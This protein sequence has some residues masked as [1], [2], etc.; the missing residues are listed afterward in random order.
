MAA[1]SQG[2]DGK[3][4]AGPWQH[5]Q[6]DNMEPDGRVGGDME[7]QPALHHRQPLPA[8]TPLSGLH[9]G[10]AFYSRAPEQHPRPR[11]QHGV[12]FT[13]PS[14][15]SAQVG[16]RLSKFVATTP[17]GETISIEIPAGLQQSWVQAMDMS[18]L[19]SVHCDSPGFNNF[20]MTL[21]PI[22]QLSSPQPTMSPREQST[23]PM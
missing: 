22:M 15:P 19:D 20:M 3:L 7:Q 14:G 21:S 18:P 10:F 2:Q 1:A 13:L 8:S 12:P 23:Q 16:G 4:R 17:A 11:Q 6:Q 9:T 5:R